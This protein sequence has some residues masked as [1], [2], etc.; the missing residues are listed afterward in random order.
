MARVKMTPSHSIVYAWL[1]ALLGLAADF[2]ASAQEF[3][4][5]RR[6]D[7]SAPQDIVALTVP[8]GASRSALAS[9]PD[10]DKAS[11]SSTDLANPLWAIP[12]ASLAPTRERPIFSPSRRPPAA[13]SPPTPAERPT[14]APVEE[15]PRN[16]PFV[17]VAAIVGKNDEIA[18]LLEE[19][20]KI[21]VRL[22][23]GESHSGWTLRSVTRREAIL[24]GY[25]RT[26]T[27]ALPDP[28][29]SQ[30]PAKP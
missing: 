10:N 9:P 20:T 14:P 5:L 2:G 1:A 3:S 18:L 11:K 29:P 19:T 21:V 4:A 8:S 24:Q 7:I 22:R 25:Q 15:K 28:L 16:P 13:A 17:L 6:P 27:L 26:A 30:H 12:I 23:T